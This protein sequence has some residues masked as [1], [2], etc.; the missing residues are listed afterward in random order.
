VARRSF[1]GHDEEIVA[2]RMSFGEG[3]QYSSGLRALRS[4]ANG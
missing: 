4:A 3:D 2:A 1:F